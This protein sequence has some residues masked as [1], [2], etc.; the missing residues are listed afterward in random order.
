MSSNPYAKQSQMWPLAEAVRA[1]IA[2]VDRNTGTSLPFDPSAQ[3]EFDLDLPPQPFVDLGWVENFQRTSAT[4]YETLRTGP[5]STLATQF[6]AEFDTPLKDNEWLEEELKTVVQT[7]DLEEIGAALG[8]IVNGFI[9]LT[10][11]LVDN[12]AESTGD[13]SEE[14]L[15]VL[16]RVTEQNI[17]A[18]DE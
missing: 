4:K 11:A 2:P 17:A 16:R 7:D 18:A 13:T 10:S 3:G 12:L 8:R 1:Y 14:V 6:R 5:Q 15:A 9:G